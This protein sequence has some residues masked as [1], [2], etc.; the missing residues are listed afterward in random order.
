MNLKLS[1]LI[2]ALLI[3]FTAFPVNAQNSPVYPDYEVQP[4][5]SLGLIAAIFDTTVNDLIRVNQIANPDLLSPGQTLKIPSFEG[6]SGVLEFI[7]VDLGEDFTYL[8]L[9]YRSTASNFVKMNKILSPGQLFTG[10]EIIIAHKDNSSPLAP[11]LLM[12]QGL[13]GF[14]ASIL[15]N[16]NPYTLTLLNSTPNPDLIPP[17]MVILGLEKTESAGIN[18]FA[19]ELASVSISPL[20]LVQGA[21]ESIV[22]H[23]GTPVQLSGSLDS[24]PLQFFSDMTGEYFSLQG[25]HA[26]SEP[27]LKDFSIT[28]AFDNGETL[29]YSQPVLLKPGIFDQDPPLTVD[30]LTIDPEVTRP[31]NELVNALISKVTPT[32]YWQ[33]MFTSPAVYQEYNSLYGTRRT[34]N[35]DSTITFHTG[36]DFAGGLHLPIYAP[37]AGQVVFAGLL[38]VRGNT[39]FIDHGCGVFSGFFHQNSLNVKVGDFVEQGQ[40]IGEVG[41]TGRVNKSAGYEGEGAHMHWE[42][43]VNG[44]QVDPLNWL[45]NEY[46]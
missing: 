29:K 27:G 40:T 43:W 5:D 19:P 6:V 11:T 15:T 30:P 37:A 21:T 33:G 18:L 23:A 14:E 39:I 31:E 42:V 9:K 35:D 8:P 28:V 16:T 41:N 25:I 12:K 38:D 10:S 1:L 45:S 20:P 36:V 13:T 3:V 7:S 34:Y 4:G 32:R 22:I 24:N 26:L 46:P 44:V 17:H 2:C